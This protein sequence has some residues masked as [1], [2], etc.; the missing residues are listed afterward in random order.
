ML[1]KLYGGPRVDRLQSEQE[2]TQALLDFARNRTGNRSILKMFR[3]RR[4]R[5]MNRGDSRSN[6]DAATLPTSKNLPVTIHVH[7]LKPEERAC[8]VTLNGDVDH[9]RDFM[10]CEKYE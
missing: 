4:S 9:R 8:P 6:P 1:K 5:S 7:E 2:L 10:E 3:G